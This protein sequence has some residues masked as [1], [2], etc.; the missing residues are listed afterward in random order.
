MPDETKKP[1]TLDHL[2][3]MVAEGFNDISGKMSTKSDIAELKADINRLDQGQEDIK[4]RLDNVAFRFE[5]RDL[6]KRVLELE[7]KAGVNRSL[8]TA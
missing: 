5:I 6:E 2:A 1:I 4:L 7:K 3:A 8:A